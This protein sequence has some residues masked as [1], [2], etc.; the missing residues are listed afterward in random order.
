MIYFEERL[1]QRFCRNKTPPTRNFLK[2]KNAAG[3]IMHTYLKYVNKFVPMH[4]AY[5]KYV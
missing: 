5:T 3:S 4:I 2:R 1:R